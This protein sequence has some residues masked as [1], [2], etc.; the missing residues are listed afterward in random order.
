MSAFHINHNEVREP[1]AVRMCTVDVMK[2]VVKLVKLEGVQKKV[3][4]VM[5]KTVIGRFS[6]LIYLLRFFGMTGSG[7]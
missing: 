6:M 2:G 1:K 5:R 7:P 4:C 3:G